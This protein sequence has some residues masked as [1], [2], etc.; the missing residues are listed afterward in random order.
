MSFFFFN[1]PAPTEIYTLS[2]HDALPICVHQVLEVLEETR[3]LTVL[4]RQL[5][6]DSELQIV[7]GSENMSSQ[8]QGCAVVL[9]TY[10]PSD[11]L[12][13]VL[14]VI[15]PTRMAYSQTVARLQA[16]ARSASDR[17]AALGVW[18]G[19]RARYLETDDNPQ[20]SARARGVR[21]SSWPLRRQE[22]RAR[23]PAGRDQGE[24]P[25]PGRRL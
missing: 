25:A 16:V 22:R 18:S 13:G 9:T 4:L 24:V 21:G 10:G 3:Y 7:I 8:L 6:G 2:L 14:G 5:I 17:M 15:G 11:R 12:K 1:D 19:R 20:A 23:I